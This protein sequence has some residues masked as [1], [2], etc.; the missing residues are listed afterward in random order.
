[1][2]IPRRCLTFDVDVT[3]ALASGAQMKTHL[4]RFGRC[5]AKTLRAAYERLVP[6]APPLDP[7]R[8]TR[9]LADDCLIDEIGLAERLGVSRSRLQHWRLY[10]QGPP[11]YKFGTARRAAVRYYWFEVLIWL[12]ANFWVRPAQPTLPASIAYRVGRAAPW[13]FADPDDP[14][15]DVATDRTAPSPNLAAPDLLPL[16]P[17]ALKEAEEWLAGLRR[18]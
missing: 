6:Q 3:S 12:R 17:A 10:D 18:A 15:G 1:M 8:Q 2:S 16:D 9:L 7:L 5:D 4:T 13:E 11:Y 14:A